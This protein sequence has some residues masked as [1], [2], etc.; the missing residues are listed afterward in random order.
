[1]LSVILLF[2]SFFSWGFGIEEKTGLAM[3]VI[4]RYCDHGM[5]KDFKSVGPYSLIQFKCKNGIVAE[6]VLSVE[7]NRYI[8]AELK[9]H[10]K[11]L[12]V[13][14][15]REDI[16]TTQSAKGPV[17]RIYNQLQAIYSLTKDYPL[18]AKQETSAINQLLNPSQEDS[19]SASLIKDLLD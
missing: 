17:K 7:S 13:F 18:K 1:M 12:L 9:A 15:Y 19:S 11:V 3:R 2:A 16:N 8:K 6:T 5:T 4:D 10:S 14:D